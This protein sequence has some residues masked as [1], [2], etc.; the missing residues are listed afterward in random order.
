MEN[1]KI[2]SGVSPIPVKG[3]CC[4]GI[5][6]FFH[7]YW[8]EFAIVLLLGVGLM[9][10][11]WKRSYDCSAPI[12]TSV[13]G[14]F[15]DF[16]GGLIGS[17][18]AY[19]SVR[20]LNR[21]LQ[22]QIQAN[23]DIRKNNENSRKVFELQ[24][25]DKTFTTL[26]ELYQEQKTRVGKLS[27]NEFDLYVCKSDSYKDRVAE[28]KNK[29]SEFYASNRLVLSSYFRLLYRIMQTIRDA[30]V[31]ECVKIRYSKIFR[32]LLS[33]DELLLLRY[34]A[35]SNYGRKMQIYINQYNILKHLPFMRLLE[36]HYDS[37]SNLSLQYKDLFD[38]IFL[39]VRKYLIN[40]FCQLLV[41]DKKFDRKYKISNRTFRV[42]VSWRLE[43]KNE[44][45]VEISYS[46]AGTTT[47]SRA[48]SDESIIKL[49]EYFMSEIFVYVSFERYQKVEKIQIQADSNTEKRSRNHT[50]WATISQVDGYPLV[51]SQVQLKE[52]EGYE[53]T[54]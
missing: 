3:R 18:I 48:V 15:G 38:N 26:V 50:I 20:L 22:E 1:A 33:E 47:A 9:C 10:F 53:I 36:F 23:I 54:A 17:L 27:L 30:K 29:F 28:A 40:A 37:I 32:C 24:Q 45:K 41:D 35:M 13:W 44:V 31:D 11:L 51:L 5:K 6:N 39:D 25:F 21:N 8:G 19:I 7:K 34:N 14:Q 16:V 49:L 42:I 12:T 4:D 43:Q 46:L 52:P 2:D